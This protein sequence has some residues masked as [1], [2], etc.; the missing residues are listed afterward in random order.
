MS[1]AMKK[2]E[3]KKRKIRLISVIAAA[4]ALFIL[5]FI[6][7]IGNQVNFLIKDELSVD[8]K[9]L[10]YILSKT[11]TQ[12]AKVNFTVTNNNLAQCRT[13]CNFSVMDLKNSKTLYFEKQIL[14]HN[15][16]INKEYIL[17]NNRKGS[18]QLIYIFRADCRNIKTLVCPT[19]E[20][21]KQKSSIVLLNYVLSDEETTIEEAVRKEI[22]N[23]TGRLNEFYIEF[24]NEEINLEKIPDR[25]TEKKELNTELNEIN[26]DFKSLN[27]TNEGFIQLWKSENYLQF[28]DIS[29][30]TYYGQIDS[31][32]S[33]LAEIDNKI[34]NIID[35]IN[36]DSGN[37]A[38][39]EQNKPR[40][41]SMI[42]FYQDA[43]NDKNYEIL[44]RLSIITSNINDYYFII[45]SSSNISEIKTSQELNKNIEELNDLLK[46]YSKTKAEGFVLDLIGGNEISI[47]N[48]LTLL[49]Y[50]YDFECNKLNQTINSIDAENINSEI[51]R[52]QNYNDSFGNLSFEN[53]LTA[54]E[55]ELWFLSLN[56]TQD[57]AVS[58][59]INNKALVFGLIENEKNSRNKTVFSQNPPED[60]YGMVIIDN[61]KNKR[62]YDE[63]CFENDSTYDIN[64]YELR[65]NIN[66][67]NIS[68]LNLD[69]ISI[70]P[71]KP[72]NETNESFMLESNSPQCCLYNEC[73]A[74]CFEN[75]IDNN[76]PVLF[77]H[78]HMFD[79]NNAPGQVMDDFSRIQIK[80]LEE[81]FVDGGEMD[82]NVDYVALP[83][84]VFGRT[85]KPITFTASYYYIQKY[86]LADYEVT[87]QKSERIE[88][89]AIRLKEIIN[90]LKYE[91]G[92][93][94]VNIV[95][96]SMGGLVAR[97][98]VALFGDGD[99]NK[100]VTINTPNHGITG[101]VEDLCSVFGSDKECQ[102]MSN[103]S[104]FMS[105]LNAQPMPKNA[106]IY[107]IRSI[108]CMMDNGETG[109][110]IVTNSSA[111]LEGAENFVIKGNCTDKLQSNLHGLVL[112]PD[113]Y[114]QTVKLLE[115]ILKE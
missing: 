5:I 19:E 92:K 6:F 55:Y 108:G 24:Q 115:K 99:I 4:V 53:E 27:R 31:I 37:F 105:R 91:T 98:Y 81:D 7:F 33:R 32:S 10:N 70:V 42:D 14:S 38:E 1:K 109:D 34:A 73:E 48:N 16:K 30:D 82:L 106:R 20:K 35:S 21:I 51:Y 76:Y 61:G 23:I 36:R 44:S 15:E 43:L 60:I 86:G 13:E 67:I 74:C 90:I 28:K 58:A 64:F 104:V 80:M 25:I 72:G 83:Y 101:R 96:H 102:D 56:K 3:T 29:F 46:N 45:K 40:V 62:F 77:I 52:Q 111:Y 17:E 113:K 65:D 94:K 75:C 87:I 18:G 39:L 78:G 26:N 68:L 11:N 59:N 107:S 97:E 22:E 110:G 12:E 79:K 66:K 54:A 8:I 93:D 103:N 112:D 88:N 47:K 100:I 114:P 50:S 49:N 41:N 89:Y 84:G 69:A 2:E 95:A 57:F 85:N 71:D 63:N 9:P